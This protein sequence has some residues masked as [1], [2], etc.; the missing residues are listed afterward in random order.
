M[1]SISLPGYRDGLVKFYEKHKEFIDIS[2]ALTILLI[3]F[4]SP[5]IFLGLYPSGADILTIWPVFSQKDS[6]I[7]NIIV[8]DVVTQFEPWLMYEGQ[9][10]RNLSIPLWNPYGATGVPLMANM[11]SAMFYP[12]N[13]PA[14]LFGL[15]PLTLLFLYFCKIYFT[16]IFTYYYLREIKLG[17]IPSIVG[18]VSFMFGGCI[19]MWL[20]WPLSNS[21]FVLPALL[22]FI[23][24]IISKPDI[25]YFIGISIVTAIGAFSGHPETFFH[26]GIISIIYFAFRFFTSG[27]NIKSELNILIKY[28][29]FS[30][31]GLALSA[32]QLI[33]FTEYMLN[34]YV[35]IARE[36][37]K[38]SI[39]WTAS[40]LNFMPEFYGSH[41]AKL[42]LQF[43]YNILNNNETLGG[44]VGISVLCIAVYAVLRAYNFDLVKFY[45]IMCVWALCVIYKITPIFE[46]TTSIP[47]FSV[48]A[49]HRLLFFVGFCIVVLGSIG[50]DKILEFRNN[51]KQNELKWFIISTAVVIAL[52]LFLSYFN[53]IDTSPYIDIQG[54]LRVQNI[55]L[56]I[57]FIQ[58]FFTLI[59]I[60]L[61]MRSYYKK[62]I[63]TFIIIIFI[64]LIFV[65]TGVHGMLYEPEISGKYFYPDNKAFDNITASGEL[66]RTT[67]I[68]SSKNNYGIYPVNTQMIYGIYDIRNYDAIENK[69]YWT[70]FNN[71]TS[72]NLNGWVTISDIDRRFLNFMGVKWIFSST[73]LSKGTDISITVNTNP[74]GEITNGTV[75]QQNFVSH[76]ANLSVIG[77]LFATY[78]RANLDSN[79][80]IILM[81]NQ[82]KIAVRNIT[83]SPDQINDNSLYLFSFDPLIDSKNKTYTLMITSDGTPGKSATLWMNNTINDPKSQLYINSTKISGSLCID[84]FYNNNNSGYIPYKK[85][86]NYYILENLNVMPRA[87]MAWNVTFI[88]NDKTTINILENKSFDW[89]S[90]IILYGKNDTDNSMPGYADVKILDYQPSYIRISVN[91]SRPGYLVLSDSYYPGW[92]AYTNNNKSE[93][94][95]TDYAFRSVKLN[96]GNSIVE[97]KYEPISVYI[98]AITSLLSIILILVLMVN[99]YIYKLF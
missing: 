91:T 29:F 49:N 93:I 84:T 43:Y 52:M 62:N 47:P 89:N 6:H 74:V 46:I 40:I 9:S 90:S 24:K 18:A 82:S 71:L 38:Y 83:I 33:P 92:N 75:I 3:I 12:F 53:R 7:Q 55:E 64:A 37:A 4:F 21:I 69:Y 14:L 61:I 11:Q 68:D 19:M 31:L 86:N 60:W 28:V 65:E 57:T 73:D 78:K 45:S 25:K 80:T 27:R 72:G 8:S 5:T 20:Y 70:L 10:L 35:L 88:D 36:Q 67:A 58:I 94:Y 76:E 22:Y 54:A 56:L 99:R 30:L 59:L 66:Y 63:L 50:L 81:E 41:S 48:I 87:F 34:S 2:T 13:W 39:P 85:Y 1:F 16:G 98:G 44:Y 95:R 15:T 42:L 26:I 23:E 32:V 79:I 97:F 17:R 77:L 96:A 51:N